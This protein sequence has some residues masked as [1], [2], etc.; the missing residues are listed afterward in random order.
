MPFGGGI[1][2]RDLLNPTS[3]FYQSRMGQEVGDTG[4]IMTSEVAEDWARRSRARVEV[5]YDEGFIT[6]EDYETITRGEEQ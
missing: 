6:E 3:N 2:V 1:P 5:V 4:I